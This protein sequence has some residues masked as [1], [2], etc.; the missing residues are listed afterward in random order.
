MPPPS[1][2]TVSDDAPSTNTSPTDAYGPWMQVSRLADRPIPTTIGSHRG[3]P[4]QGSSAGPRGSTLTHVESSDTPMGDPPTVDSPRPLD[5]PFSRD[6]RQTRGSRK[7][8]SGSLS[9][10]K[11]TASFKSLLGPTVG[12]TSSPS[13]V[14][15]SPAQQLPSMGQT[16]PTGPASLPLPQAPSTAGPRPNNPPLPQLQPSTHNQSELDSSHMVISLPSHA[17]LVSSDPTSPL[18]ILVGLVNEDMDVAH[19]DPPGPRATSPLPHRILEVPPPRPP[20]P[21]PIQ[22][23]AGTEPASHDTTME[24]PVPPQGILPSHDPNGPVVPVPTDSR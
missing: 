11:G 10:N 19:T 18:P 2:V 21:C 16:V 5:S 7:V 8:T 22:Q 20:D 3:S 4:P 9:M 14:T 6:A 23:S 1:V 12:Q 13:P 15:S 24:E 17:A